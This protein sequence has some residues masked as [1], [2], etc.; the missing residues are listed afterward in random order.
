MVTVIMPKEDVWIDVNNCL[1]NEKDGDENGY[2]D[3]VIFD[4][5]MQPSFGTFSQ[6]APKQFTRIQATW[7]QVKTNLKFLYWTK[8]K[9]LPKISSSFI[10]RSGEV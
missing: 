9:E 2:V 6:I 5:F 3:A 10:T 7:A 8:R 1:P 4:Y